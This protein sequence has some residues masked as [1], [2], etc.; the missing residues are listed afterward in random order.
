[1]KNAPFFVDD[2]QN[3]STLTNFLLNKNNDEYKNHN[4]NQS[5][6][7]IEAAILIKI[8]GNKVSALK[9]IGEGIL[10]GLL[11]LGTA[12]VYSVSHFTIKLYIIDLNTRKILWYDWFYQKG[13]DPNENSLLEAVNSL[14]EKMPEKK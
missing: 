8:T 2:S 5:T 14:V 12:S 3:D 6:S 13:K 7:R 1:L 9:S 10:T 11:T 4:S